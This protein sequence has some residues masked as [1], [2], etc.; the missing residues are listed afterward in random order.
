[1]AIDKKENYSIIA[2]FYDRLMDSKRYEK[3]QEMIN[4]LVEK[5]SIPKNRAL[6]IGCGT[7]KISKILADLGFETV[8]V[9]VSSSM[10]RVARK[11]YPEI[12]FVNQ[13]V[14]KLSFSS[15][16]D[17]AT[18]LYDSLNYL[19][20]YKELK[21][22]LKNTASSLK[23]NGIFF[24][25]IITKDHV[26]NLQKAKDEVY[27][28]NGKE[29]IFSYSGKGDIL[30]TE[31]KIV[32]KKEVEIHKQRGYDKEEI[33]E[34]VIGPDFDVLDIKEERGDSEVGR[35]INRFYFIFKKR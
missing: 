5:Y 26:A 22:A 16:F 18:S 19:L 11:K 34:K 7:G 32:G 1:M 20:K 10:L 9:D 8:G 35:Y 2:S 12:D 31:I 3:W 24:F 27:N 30:K 23:K 15:Q 33:K 28:I 4:N 13:D 14:L 6:D 29:V 17:F 21:R 25:D